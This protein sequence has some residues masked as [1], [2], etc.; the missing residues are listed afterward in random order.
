[1]VYT[2]YDELNRMN[3]E[4]RQKEQMARQGLVVDP[5]NKSQKPQPIADVLRHMA[6]QENCDGVPYDQMQVAADYIE[7]LEGEKVKDYDQ[8]DYSSIVYNVVVV[9]TPEIKDFTIVAIFPKGHIKQA[10]EFLEKLLAQNDKLSGATCAMHWREIEQRMMESNPVVNKL[11]REL[12]N[13][14]KEAKD[15]VEAAT[16]TRLPVP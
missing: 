9:I 4:R 7:Q 11:V 5:L 8:L 12:D 16:P 10:T 3:V 1:M 15:L 2:H 6:S 13:M 14:I